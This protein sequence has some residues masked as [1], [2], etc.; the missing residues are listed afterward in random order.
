MLKNMAIHELAVLA[1][2][3]GQP[4]ALPPAP[5]QRSKPPSPKPRAPSPEPE[6]PSGV[7][8]E[9]IE[10]VV[11]D[12]EY[13]EMLTLKGAPVATYFIHTMQPLTTSYSLLQPR[14]PSRP[15]TAPV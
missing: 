4:F 12:V 8:V 1:T 11:P 3:Y 6:P 7:T 5:P 13:S 2:Y 10:S 15:L 9:N 14:R